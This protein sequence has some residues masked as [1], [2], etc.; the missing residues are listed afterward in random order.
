MITR[1]IRRCLSL[2]ATQLLV[3]AL[4]L[5]RLDYSNVIYVG[6]PQQQLGRLQRI[7]NATARLHHLYTTAGTPIACCDAAALVISTT[8][9]YF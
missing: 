2:T 4:V 9:D 5:S 1:R 6:L 8:A 3:Q 7:Q